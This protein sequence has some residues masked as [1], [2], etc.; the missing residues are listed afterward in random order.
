MTRVDIACLLNK[1]LTNW[2]LH[3]TDLYYLL[4]NFL[5]YTICCEWHI[6]ITH[7]IK[8]IIVIANNE[9]IS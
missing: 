9:L 4:Y 5:F 6:N 2:Y 8:T 1:A 3:C 7:N